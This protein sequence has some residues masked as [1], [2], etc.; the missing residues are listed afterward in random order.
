MSNA[1]I[2]QDQNFHH[3][4]WFYLLSPRHKTTTSGNVWQLVSNCATRW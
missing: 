3:P 1:L 4:T 2:E